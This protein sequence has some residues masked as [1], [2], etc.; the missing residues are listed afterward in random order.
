MKKKSF[1]KEVKIGV[2]FLVAIFILYFGVNFLKG[3]NIFSPANNYVVVFKNVSGMLVSDPVTINGLKIGQV[4]GMNFDPSKPTEIFVQIQMEKD[5]KLKKGSKIF[6]DVSMM[7]GSTLI[8]DTS[9]SQ[10]DFLNSGDTIQGE[11]KSGMVDAV[12]NMVP[13]VEDILPKLDSMVLNMNTLLTNEDIVK[14]LSS[15]TVITADL[16]K[17]VYTMNQM[18]ATINAK[19]PEITNNM[20]KSLENVE[21]ITKQINSLD[22]QATMS[23]LDVTLENFE[24]ISKQMNSKDNS[25]GL[26]FNDRQ[27]Y[28]SINGV[29][30][31]A[32]SLLN[33]VKANPSKYINVKVF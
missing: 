26:L 28:D 4:K 30:E 32:S 15:V 5:I 18:M 33:D 25:I 7:G 19:L 8:L 3:I 6:M 20:D 17:S 13:H 23:K 21:G 14:I 27:L 2:T 22:I 16:S 9:K 10:S 12:T 24:K 31:N 1:S 11:K 29:L